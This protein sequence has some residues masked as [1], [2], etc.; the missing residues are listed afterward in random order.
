MP[1]SAKQAL[2]RH[3][4]DNFRYA[5]AFREAAPRPPATT[6]LPN[7]FSKKAATV[8]R[9]FFEMFYAPIFYRDKGYPI[10]APKLNGKLF[11]K[12]EYLEAYHTANPELMV[13]P[14]CD[15]GM[16]GAQLDHWLAQKHFPE[17]NCYAQNLVEICAACN[18]R[19]NK[20]EKKPLDSNEPDPFAYWF[21]PHLRPA[22]EHF[23]IIKRDANVRLVSNDSINQ[24]RLDNLDNLINLS[25]RWS[26]EWQ[27]Q[28]KRILHKIYK[29]KRR[30][31]ILDEAGLRAKL[32]FW[33][34]DAEDGIGQAPYA[35][36][37][38]H[39]L[40]MAT[41]RESDIFKEFLK[42][43]KDEA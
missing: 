43:A 34:T 30:S 20:G 32:E 2:T 5:E 33:K 21:H 12:D 9:N 25:N 6:P 23:E 8:Y 24:T 15:G 35:M 28:V 31:E 39:L 26:R 36:L 22:A 16:D 18:S 1:V 41:C 38:E 13:C 11:S 29:C 7:G 40:S 42:Y 37:T 4:E 10:D 27:N 19:S 14:F 17:L 3:Y